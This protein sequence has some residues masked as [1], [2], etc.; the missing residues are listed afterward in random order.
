MFVWGSHEYYRNE[1]ICW[2]GISLKRNTH[3]TSWCTNTSCMKPPC[4]VRFEILRP[5]KKNTAGTMKTRVLP[6]C[7]EE[8]M[9]RIIPNFSKRMRWGDV[10]PQLYHSN[11]AESLKNSLN[12]PQPTIF[13]HPKPSAVK[14]H[15][16]TNRNGLACD[17]GL[18]ASIRIRSPFPRRKL[19]QVLRGA[20]PFFQ[21]ALLP[22]SNHIH[23]HVRLTRPRSRVCK[24]AK[25]LHA[26]NATASNSD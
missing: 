15:Q 22:L 5:F 12:N 4:P 6:S 26:K 8:R 23:N 7:I 19:S 10:I 24:T 11:S 1:G 3:N 21:S 14:L 25:F 18:L 17:F 16:T 13:R 9:D 2:R 20:M